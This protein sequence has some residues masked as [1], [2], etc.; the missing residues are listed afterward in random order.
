MIELGD[1]VAQYHPSENI[2]L[3]KGIV[4]FSNSSRYEVQWVSYNK[5]WWMEDYC[6]DISYLNRRYLLTKMSY[7]R[8]NIHTNIVILNKVGKNGLG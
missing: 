6:E 5:K 1:L 7:H 4:I 8:N 3:K 2:I